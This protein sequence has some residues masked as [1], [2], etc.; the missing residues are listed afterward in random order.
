LKHS[1]C[2]IYNNYAFIQVAKDLTNSSI[3]IKGII[4]QVPH[5]D[6]KAASK[7]A[8]QSRGVVG[9]IRAAALSVADLIVSEML[10]FPP[11]L[12]KIVGS[13]KETSYMNLTDELLQKASEAISG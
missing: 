1:S 9:V 5:L 8:L 6:G 12:V 4:A 7:R 13:A 10:G 3:A 2:R 11:V